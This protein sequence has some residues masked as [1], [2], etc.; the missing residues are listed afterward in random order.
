[1]ETSF[2]IHPFVAAFAALVIGFIWYHPK[3]F[4]TAWMKASGMTEAK[5]KAANPVKI[6]GLALLCAFFVAMVLQS[7]CVH[8]MGAFSMVGGDVEGA[9]PSYHAFMNDYGI[10]F[11]TFKHG[12]FHGFFAGLFFA[13]P[14]IGT[15]ALFEQKSAKH[16]FINAGYWTV[17]CMVMG[18]IV[19]A[20]V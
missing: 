8:Q 18:G 19:C 20:W 7:L 12:V 10:A 9:L 3:V 5:I 15:N 2:F 6:Y 4:G 13:L 11:R 1:M 16:A 14:V 17:T